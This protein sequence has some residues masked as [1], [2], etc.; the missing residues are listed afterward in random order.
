MNTKDILKLYLV[1]V[2][3]VLIF[4]IHSNLP[5][6]ANSFISK[7]NTLHGDGNW[8]IHKMSEYISYSHD[9]FDKYPIIYMYSD[10]TFM[11]SSSYTC[12]KKE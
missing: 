1:I 11:P 2:V 4:V 8:E 10:D 7:C 12:F 3:L 9:L 5:E 6:S